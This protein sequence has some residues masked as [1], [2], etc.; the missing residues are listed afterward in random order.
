MTTEFYTWHEKEQAFNNLKK[1]LIFVYESI[2]FNWKTPI[3]YTVELTAQSISTFGTVYGVIPTVS[4]FIGI[5]QLIRCSLKD[6]ANDLN[7]LDVYVA[8]NRND[9]KINK[10]FRNIIVDFSTAKQLSFPP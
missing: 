8:W 2:P 6:I 1:N 10:L 9:K 5:M 4:L 3:G 7:A